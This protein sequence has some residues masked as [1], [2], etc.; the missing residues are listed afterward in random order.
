[1]CAL[2]RNLW[3]SAVIG[4]SPAVTVVLSCLAAGHA[5][6]NLPVTRG[7]RK[8][9]VFW[10]VMPRRRAS[11]PDDLKDCNAFIFRG[12]QS[13]KNYIFFLDC[14]TLKLKTVR[15]FNPSAWGHLNPSSYC[16]VGRLFYGVFKLWSKL[17]RK[18]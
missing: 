5:K 14:S 1:M 7:A 15:S 2:I 16:D 4:I 6:L 11:I 8:M 18:K 12:K 9:G 3:G 10:Y 13:K 17:Q